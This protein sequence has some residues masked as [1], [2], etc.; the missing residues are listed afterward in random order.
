MFLLENALFVL[1]TKNTRCVRS[2]HEKQRLH[3]EVRQKEHSIKL[4]AFKRI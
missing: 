1:L 4:K 3:I 2:I